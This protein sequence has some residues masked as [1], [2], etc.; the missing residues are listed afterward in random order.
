MSDGMS[1]WKY[2]ND[3]AVE[4]NTINIMEN[5]KQIKYNPM[6]VYKAAEFVAA[7]NNHINKNTDEVYNH[8]LE[9]IK[10]PRNSR[11]VASMGYIVL[12]EEQRGVTYV[13]VYVDP[14]ISLDDVEVTL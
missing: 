13:E 6:Q 4:T 10:N 2:E 12:Y 7:Y 1:D 14:A 9:K 3:I 8:I 11:Y 5:K